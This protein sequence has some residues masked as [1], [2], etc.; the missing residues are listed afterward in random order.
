MKREEAKICMS[1]PREILKVIAPHIYKNL[2]II[3]AYANGAEIQYRSKNED[4]WEKAVPLFREDFEY[5]VKPSSEQPTT[6]WKPKDN[7][8]FLY[9][10]LDGEVMDTRFNGTVFH[11]KIVDFGNC[12]KSYEEA[13]EARERVRVA[14]K[15]EV[16]SKTEIIEPLCSKPITAQN[17]NPWKP[18]K[19]EQYF[20]INML[21]E[22]LPTKWF[23][24]ES[25]EI[26][27]RVGNCFRSFEEAKTVWNYVRAA[28]NV[29]R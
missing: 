7:E 2:D 8:R 26:A 6:L 25:D 22:V 21:G 13:E 15:G 24:L 12:F 10:G 14:L 1:I 28:L 18:Q 23:D 27:F 20:C 11:H 9:V 29:N 16:L 17:S 4:E 3:Q 19:G 5:R